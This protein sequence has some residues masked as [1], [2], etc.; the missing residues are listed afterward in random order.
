VHSTDSC[1]FL[2]ISLDYR[3]NG[4]SY[5]RSLSARCSKLLNILNMLRGTWWGGAPSSLLTIYRALIRDSMAYG[6]LT[7]P[8][9]NH[10]SMRHLESIQLQALRTCLG[11]RKTTTNVVLE[12]GEGPLRFRFELLT[13][14]YILKIFA[15]DSHP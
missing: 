14:K 6:C 12:A 2:G 15:L 5:I 1:K 13:S 3:L 8:F 9:N 4:N 11:L 7:F 10:S